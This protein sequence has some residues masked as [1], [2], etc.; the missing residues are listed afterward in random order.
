MKYFAYD[1]KMFSP[2]LETVIPDIH[3]LGIAQLQGYKLYFHK[4]G[5]H[6]HSGKCNLMK[7]HSKDDV[8]Y[9]VVYEV[10]ARE[11]H[12]LDK[13]ESL[14]YGNQEITLKVE[15]ES[16]VLDNNAPCYAFTYVANKE[17]VFED[18]VPFTWYKNLVVSGAKQH[19]LPLS[20]VHFLEQIA[21]TQDPNA[22]RETKHKR[23]LE[24]NI[25]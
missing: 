3:C 23:F 12:V 13:S 19:Q 9:G 17:N 15:P 11:K 18:L 8:V 24:S 25:S 1:D 21:S 5:T 2:L 7:T 6:D 14:G 20:Y 22:A 16:F 10:L 4:R